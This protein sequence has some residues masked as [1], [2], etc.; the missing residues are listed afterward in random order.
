MGVQHGE[1]GR[2]LPWPNPTTQPFFDAASEGRLDLQR[3]PR[4][5]FFFYPRSH[6]PVCWQ[7]DWRWETTSGRG[8][9][10]S[11]TIDRVAHVPALAPQAPLALALVE[12]E[13]GPRLPGRIVDCDVDEVHVGMPVEACYE[14]CERVTVVHFRPVD[15]ATR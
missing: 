12:L 2:P 6:C 5:G 4:H 15:A 1:G 3:C 9:V 10:H 11:F 7:T 8:V 14:D 13:E